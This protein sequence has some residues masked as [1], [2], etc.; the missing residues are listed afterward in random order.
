MS[1]FDKIVPKTAGT[2]FCQNVT[3]IVIFYAQCKNLIFFRNVIV[4]FY[5][6]MY[7]W[8]FHYGVKCQWHLFEM[9][10]FFLHFKSTFHFKNAYFGT[11]WLIKNM[12]RFHVPSLF[13][14][15]IRTYLGVYFLN[16]MRAS[17]NIDNTTVFICK[18]DNSWFF[19]IIW[20]N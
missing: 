17:Q 19:L 4:I 5:P 6:I 11:F 16:I 15:Q 1:H 12:Q 9:S 2:I 14:Y 20:M 13:K 3:N 18:N 10:I 7:E 8:L